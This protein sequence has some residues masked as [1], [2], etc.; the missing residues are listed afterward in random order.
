MAKPLLTFQ[1]LSNVIFNLRDLF[2]SIMFLMHVE[3]DGGQM[4]EVG[5]RRSGRRG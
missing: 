4:S 1:R 3:K 2:L 5:G